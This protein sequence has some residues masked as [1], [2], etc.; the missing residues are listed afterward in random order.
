[1]TFHLNAVGLKDISSKEISLKYISSKRH[2]VE[3]DIRL[4]LS[5]F[6]LKFRLKIKRKEND[7]TLFVRHVFQQNRLQT[8]A[9][10][11]DGAR[12]AITVPVQF[13]EALKAERNAW[14]DW[15]KFRLH[16]KQYSYTKNHSRFAYSHFAYS[17]FA[18]D[19]SRFAYSH[20]A[21]SRFAYSEKIHFKFPSRLLVIS[22]KKWDIEY[23]FLFEILL[24]TKK[25]ILHNTRHNLN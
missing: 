13:H 9:S 11:R 12:G 7:G 1:M 2:I 3:Y 8:V 5:K 21:Y 18:F 14:S 19:L 17:R 6:R 24:I 23:L 10:S 22:D 4:K 15:Q 16:A 20:F 25:Y